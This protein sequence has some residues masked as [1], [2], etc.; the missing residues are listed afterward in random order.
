MNNRK[1]LEIFVDL[2]EEEDIADSLIWGLCGF[3]P[4]ATRGTGFV[5]RDRALP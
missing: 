5:Q 3:R 4:L 1:S 2:W